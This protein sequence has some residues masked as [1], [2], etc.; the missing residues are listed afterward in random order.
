MLKPRA[1]IF[2]RRPTDNEMRLKNDE[3]NNRN[4]HE[5]FRVGNKRR[6]L[7]RFPIIPNIHIGKP[8]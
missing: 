7:I 5:F 1:N 4:E 3:T 8:A 2:G 6:R